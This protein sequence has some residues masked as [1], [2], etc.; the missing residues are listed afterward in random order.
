M[1][2]PARTAFTSHPSDHRFFS[3]MA[4]AIAVAVFGGFANTYG[5]KVLTGT[6]EVPGIVHLHAAIF[7]S[8]LVLFVLQTR[9]VRTGRTPV[10]RRIGTAGGVLAALMVV[11]G[12]QTA[13]SVARLGHRGI[14]GVEFSTV[15]GFLLLNVATAV[16]FGV[17]VAAGIVTRRD[18]Q[19]HK[20]WM[21]LANAGTL[22]GPGVS[23]L[24]IVTGNTP[25]IALLVMAFLLAGPIYDY[26]TRRRVHRVYLIGVPI[27]F[28]ALPPVVAG[29]A[30][31]AVW[32]ALA[33]W[34][35]G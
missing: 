33:A 30:D 25:L 12:I 35:M 24:P 21:L 29:M 9:L 17:F 16:V 34:M 4:V 15:E 11:I 19:S 27:A 20:R 10:H 31:T 2:A 1:A 32:R 8:W 14:P 22:I 7:A 13:V 23:R 5:P 3:A 18:A 6:P 28:V 26:V